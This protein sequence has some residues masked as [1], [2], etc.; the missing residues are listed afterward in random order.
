MDC[1]TPTNPHGIRPGESLDIF[2]LLEKEESQL[3]RGMPREISF[4]G[5]EYVPR[6]PVMKDLQAETNINFMK[7]QVSN[8]DK[9]LD[10]IAAMARKPGT[11]PLTG[12][13]IPGTGLPRYTWAARGTTA[14]RTARTQKMSSATLEATKNFPGGQHP[15]TVATSFGAG[16]PATANSSLIGSPHTTTK[17]PGA[18]TGSMIAKPSVAPQIRPY[19][20]RPAPRKP[21]NGDV[22]A[23][24]QSPLSGK[25]KD[26]DAKSRLT[27]QKS[28]TPSSGTPYELPRVVALSPNAPKG[29][30][31]VGTVADGGSGR[32]GVR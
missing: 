9:E 2:Q 25:T 15:R 13:I 4:K 10:E 5:F 12:K 18:N 27:S 30:S 6:I 16:S 32:M 11:E 7:A 24:G 20:A 3:R 31:G 23:Q 19:H 8:E 14:G 28:T 17:G 1:I 21:R 29:L 22:W 26:W